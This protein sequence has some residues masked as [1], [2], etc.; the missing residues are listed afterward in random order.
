M[1]RMYD[2]TLLHL[3]Y[4]IY[5]N[6]DVFNKLKSHPAKSPQMKTKPFVHMST[7]HNVDENVKHCYVCE[8]DIV[9]F[10]S[11]A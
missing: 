10:S 8:R 9:R 3:K 1:I 11:A 5:M 2:W 7:K 4:C 6:P